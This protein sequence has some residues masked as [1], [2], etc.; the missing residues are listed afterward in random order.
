MNQVRSTTS[1]SGRCGTLMLDGENPEER[2][3]STCLGH[4]ICPLADALIGTSLG[5]RHVGTVAA[6]VPG[7]QQPACSSR[8]AGGQHLCAAERPIGP[9]QAKQ[10]AGTKLI[11][12][13]RSTAIVTA[14]CIA[15][16]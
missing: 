16:V 14:R 3:S 2:I 15:P 7:V 8:C 11:V 6:I 10:S 9:L 1:D 12:N 5:S 4:V 13:A